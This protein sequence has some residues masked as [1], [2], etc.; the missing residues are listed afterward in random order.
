MNIRD[1]EHMVAELREKRD[2]DL[3]DD[4]EEADLILI[5]TCSVRDKPVRKLFS[6]IGAFNKHKK[7]GAK[8]GVCGCTA[9]HLGEE[10]IKQAPSVNFVLGARNISKITQAVDQDKM[11]AVD[12]DHDESQYVFSD[13]RSSAFRSFINI[14]I[15]CD[16]R[17]SFCIV[18]ST[19]GKEISIPE[20]LILKESEKAAQ[21]GVKEIF[22]LGQN[23]NNYGKTF[24]DKSQKGSF[25][26]LL[27]N[28][29][30]IDGVE[31]IRFTSPHPL[32]MD[33]EFIE[34]F[35]SN[36]KISKSIHMPLQSGSTPILKKM[37]RGYSQSWFLDRALKIRSLVPEAFISTDIIVGFPGESDEDFLGTLKVI[38]EVKFEQIFNFK[39]SPRPLTPAKDFHP[40]VPDI[41]S[42]ERLIEV[43]ERHKSY[44]PQTLQNKIGKKET[45]LI[46]KFD[47]GVFIG[48]SDNNFTVKIKDTKN[49]FSENNYTIGDI[50]PITI[51]GVE[52][53][54]LIGHIDWWYS[55]APIK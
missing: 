3:T 6:E 21:R 54:T 4:V 9:S 46:E 14:S 23:V 33:D 48:K 52:K 43:I 30:Q 8:I 5:N 10:I 42:S 25:T 47:E 15:G 7:K 11:V 19:R 38:D 39:Y 37:K 12:I 34:E 41:I 20:H 22:L 16:K 44:F 26:Q 17:C 49:P 55:I 35:A 1:S 53:S 27:K 28:I 29:S 24:S 45:I 40:Q 13:Y 2:Y 31:R 36:P 32:H 51:D 50:Y 18:P